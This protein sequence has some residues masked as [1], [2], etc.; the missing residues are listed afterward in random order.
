MVLCRAEVKAIDAN[1]N[2]AVTK[3][4]IVILF[5]IVGESCPT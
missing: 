4:I 3:E 1:I 2:D 5:R